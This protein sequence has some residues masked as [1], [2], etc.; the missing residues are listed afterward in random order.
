MKKF[1]AGIM[2]VAMM[3]SFAACSSGEAPSDDTANDGENVESSADNSTLLIGGIGPLTGGAASY[4]NS[5]K[6]GAEI[7]IAEINE[8]G[9][10][11]AGDGVYTFALDFQDDES[12]EDKA[13]TAYNSLMDKG[14]NKC[15]L[16]CSKRIIKTR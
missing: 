16:Y 1:L 8:A 10:I 3:F 6:Q 15:A 2:T 9:G 14:M 5:V 12:S 11:K 4:G 13:I 7:A